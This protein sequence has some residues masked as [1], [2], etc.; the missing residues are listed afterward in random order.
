LLA[1]HAGPLLALDKELK[2]ISE[3]GSAQWVGNFFLK[4]LF[5]KIS[6]PYNISTRNKHIESGFWFVIQTEA[7]LKEKILTRYSCF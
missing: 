6:L 4:S 5:L 7:L 3:T 1:N 2:V